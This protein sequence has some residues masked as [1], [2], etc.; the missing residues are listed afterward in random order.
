MKYDFN[1]LTFKGPFVE[2]TMNDIVYFSIYTYRLLK[3]IKKLMVLVNILNIKEFI[4][5]I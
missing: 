4:N 2:L 1:H 5:E 3:E